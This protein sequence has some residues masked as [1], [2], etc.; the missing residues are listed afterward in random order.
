MYE[1]CQCAM[2]SMENSSLLSEEY[3]YCLQRG[4]DPVT[5]NDGVD[6]EYRIF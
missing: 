2:K 5:E 4:R 6:Y 1:D 3:K